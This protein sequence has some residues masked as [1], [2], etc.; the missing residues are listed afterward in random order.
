MAKTLHTLFEFILITDDDFN[1]RG[2]HSHNEH[3]QDD[4]RF[5][6]LTLE[7]MK[8]ACIFETPICLSTAFF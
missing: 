8:W 2:E 6:M 5:K 3:Q 1:N 4:T 7:A